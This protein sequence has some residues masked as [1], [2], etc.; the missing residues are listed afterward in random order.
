[1][2]KAK[3][4]KAKVIEVDINLFRIQRKTQTVIS[5]SSQP[6]LPRNN[7]LRKRKLLKRLSQLLRKSLRKMTLLLSRKNLPSKSK[8]KLHLSE[9]PHLIRKNLL[10]N[11]AHQKKKVKK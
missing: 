4:L 10:K 8:L 1:M 2:S 3:N 7:R 11:K 6:N 5:H 9:K